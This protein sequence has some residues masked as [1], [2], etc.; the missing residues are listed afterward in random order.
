MRIS[1]W[2]SD[3]CSSDL[4]AGVWG[5]PPEMLA[6]IPGQSG[7]MEEKRERARAIMTELGY[8]PDNPLRLKLST[9]NIAVFRDP[10]IIVLDQLK[11]I[12]IEA[13][14]DVNAVALW[15]PLIARRDFTIAVNLTG[16]SIDD[17]DPVL[18]ENFS[19]NSRRN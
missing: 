6:A 14:L 7:D 19:C 1:D 13:E 3:V 12:H 4:P 2:S 16:N 17:P 5:M 10:A 8:G 11:K 18:F 9:R 15:Y